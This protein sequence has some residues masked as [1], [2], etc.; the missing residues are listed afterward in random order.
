MTRNLKTRSYLLLFV[1]VLIFSSCEKE[2]HTETVVKGTVRN[3]V[4]G[5]AIFP[6]FLIHGDE[7]LATAHEDGTYEIT[8][9][10]PGI[11]SLVCSAINYGDKTV[12]V[13]VADRKTQFNDVHLSPDKQTG[14][15]YGEFHDKVLYQ[16]QLISDPAKVDWNDK[17][18]FD[19]VSGATIQTSFDMPS[20]EIY[21]GDSLF[22]YSDG[23]G[24]F[25]FDIQC[26][27]YPITGSSSGYSDTSHII[28]IEPNSE[29]YVHYILSRQ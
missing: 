20:S 18:L 12:Q 24:Q 26:G 5:K 23:Y 16:D 22:A 29:V 9:L 27:T 6:A 7:L 10:D 4:D 25:W 21:V 15:V 3:Q 1:M 19:G 14:R 11:Y 8:G 28:S 2:S 13:E 17:E